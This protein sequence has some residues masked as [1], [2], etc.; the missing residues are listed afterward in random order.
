MANRATQDN[1]L[2]SEKGSRTRS[3]SGAKSGAGRK[4]GGRGQAGSRSNPR[5]GGSRSG[6]RRDAKPQEPALIAPPKYRKGSMRITP[7]GG[8]GEIGRNMNVIEYNGHI[9]LIDCGVLFPE[10]EQPGVDLIL[11][12]FSYIKDKLDQIDALVLTHGH[13]DHI[14]G[15]PYLLNLR[16]DIPLIG[17]KLTL[18]FVDAKCEEHHQHPTEV[19]VKGRDKL[20]VGPF[21]LEFVAVTHS[22]P[23]ALAVSVRTPAGHIVDTGDMKIDPLPLDHRLTDL[24]EFARLGESGVDLLMV[25][26]TNAE[27]PG[28]VKPEISIAPALDK[29]FDEA[30]RKIIVASFS[31]HVHR[32]QQVVD[33]AHKHGRKVVFAGRSMVRNMGIASDL[34]YLHLPEDT[35]VDLKEAHKIPDDKIVYMC[36]GSQGEPMA[37]LGRIA[38]GTHRDIHINEFDTVIMAS[39]LIPGNEHGVYKVINKLIRKGARVVNRD[40]AAIHVSGHSDEGE[41]LHFYNIVQPKC[42]MPIHGEN[43]HLVANGLIAVKTGV[44]PQNVVLAE[45]GDVVDLYHGKAAVV[46]SVPCGYVYVDGD[47]VGE[48]TD[49][50]LEQRRILGTEGFVSAFAVVDSETNEVVSGP[51]VYLNAVAED[52]REFRAIEDQI[53]AQLEDAMSSGTHD[54]YKLQQLMRRTLGGWISRKLHRRPVIVPVVADI[55]IDVQESGR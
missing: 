38:D 48:L 15:V 26:S 20:K 21:N 51:K 54:T 12:D 44:D 32:V 16:P 36:T 29:A 3:R 43:R 46:G 14:G 34:G 13:E 18:A 23:D 6:G 22:I 9:L 39:S 47:S 27:V 19:E 37:A 30:Q 50:E 4:S 11:P 42:A 40:N 8:L 35:V 53:V 52:E 28:F 33:A 41:L 45:D 55:A 25:D 31:S 2:K 7:L 10:E 5:R 49:D 24:R 1:E 17:S